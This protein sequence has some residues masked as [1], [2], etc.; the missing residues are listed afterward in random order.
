MPDLL[1]S[2]QTRDLGH[3]RIVAGLWGV[4]LK[5]AETDVALKELSAS[6]LDP[7]SVREIVDSLS[8][9]TRS[10]LAVLAEVGGKIPWA[11]FARQFGELR[12]AGPG[13]RDRE[14]VYL[15]PASAA[16]TLFYRA[17][18]A[19][20]FFDTPS[21]AQE[22]AYIPDDLLP[23]IPCRDE[24]LLILAGEI[25]GRPATPKERALPLPASDRLL[26]DATTLLAAL[27]MGMAPTETPIPVRVVMEFLVAAK[28]MPGHP[29]SPSRRGAGARIEQSRSGEVLRPAAT[30]SF[31]EMPRLEALSMLAEAWQASETFNELRQI[32]GLVCEGEWQNS[33]LVTRHSLLAHLNTIPKEKWWNLSAFIHAIKGKH[34]DFQRPAG[35]YDSWFIKREADGIYL[36]GF[37]HWDDVDGALIRY[38]ITGP[39]FWLGMVE[40][41]TPSDG[42]IV[43]AF[44]VV[45]NVE[46]QPSN[47][48]RSTFDE[49][50][51]LHVSSQGRIT[52]PRLLPRAVRYQ[53]SRFCEWEEGGRV[54][55]GSQSLPPESPSHQR[56]IETPRDEYHYRVTTRSLK[57]AG[58]QRLKVGQLLSLLAKNAAAEIPPA[59]V[60]SLKRWETNGTEARVEVQTILRLSRPEVLEELRK[61]RA[62]RFLGESLGPVTVVVKPGAQARVLA[63]LAELGLLA[64]AVHGE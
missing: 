17:L 60:R 55:A 49:L 54:A 26:D 61:S 39:L 38:L 15:H 31:L 64:E 41:A 3:L 33:P 1:H 46:R 62:G 18:L 20:A 40:L 53:I 25:L 37:A 29:S 34:P 14:Q 8:A 51:K 28:I 56:R 44:R 58:E 4:E 36:R 5:S 50:A 2:L 19:R 7:A 10:A 32:P 45:S 13:R 57:K 48:R 6:L 12:Q 42:E 63:A 21:G 11:A 30:K 35:D 59:F 24:H 43:T 16:E 23:M 47:V 52:V 22:F 9:E 27:R